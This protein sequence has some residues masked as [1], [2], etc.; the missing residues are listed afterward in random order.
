M[1]LKTRGIV[2][3]AI[4]Y[5]ETSVIIDIYTEAKGLQSYIVSGVRSKK[6]K[7][8]AGYLQVT[9]LVD[10]VVYFQENVKKLFRTKEIKAA[11]N[12]TSLPFDVKKGTVGIFIAEVIKKT[13]FESEGN[14]AMFR[15]FFDTYVFID[16]TKQPVTNVH[17]YFLVA[18]THYMGFYPQMDIR[19]EYRF[20]DMVNGIF[21]REKPNHLYFF[22]E[23]MTN[24]LRQL[25]SIEMRDCHLV[26]ITGKER[27]TFLDKMLSY[28]NYH[29]DSFA[30][31]KSHEILRT[32]FG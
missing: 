21:L 11:Y 15:F 9:S 29:I 10:M 25:L 32:V 3:K 19:K 18:Y 17:L 13:I 22:D 7:A 8:V 6:P 5:S 16:R 2:L 24:I 26:T 1:L 28:Y 23:K 4:K 20:F 31:I 12:Y 27:N 30:G 14:P